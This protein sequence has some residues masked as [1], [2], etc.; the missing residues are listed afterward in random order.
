MSNEPANTDAADEP[1]LPGLDHGS[2]R[3]GAEPDDEAAAERA[4]ARAPD[5]SDAYDE[6][7]ERGA[8]VEGEGA[9]VDVEGQV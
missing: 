2:A 4:A 9:I 7:L 5:V 6:A 1:D 8:E 3:A